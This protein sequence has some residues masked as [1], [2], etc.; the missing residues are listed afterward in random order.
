MR[1]N[2]YGFPQMFARVMGQPGSTNTTKI[3]QLINSA[4]PWFAV[5]AVASFI[6]L[7]MSISQQ[8]RLNDLQRQSADMQARYEE[9]LQKL[10]TD[11]AWK[12]EELKKSSDAKEREMR[13]LEYYIVDTDQKQVSRGNLKQSETWSARKNK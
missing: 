11:L 5:L 7:G 6:G 12:I 1:Y 13:M 9:R 4:L 8:S 2:R 3:V 10:Q